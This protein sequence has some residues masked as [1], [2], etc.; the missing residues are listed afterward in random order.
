MHII[1]KKKIREDS[2]KIIQEWWRNNYKKEEAYEITIQ[3]AVKLQSFM[4][5]FLVRKK[6]LRYITL[7]IYYQSFCDKLQDVLCNYVKK[8]L[9]KLFKEEY[10]YKPKKVKRRNVKD[11]RIPREIIN[12][13][14]KKL[15]NLF[16]KKT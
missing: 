13:R 16:H 9:F 11:K 10:L 4:R 6:V 15:F 8:E 1:V 12:K 2:A 3:S 7:A 14:K 5:G